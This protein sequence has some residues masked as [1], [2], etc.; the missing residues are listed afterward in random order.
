MRRLFLGVDGGG[1]STG[2]SL[3]DVKGRV[4]ATASKKTI[5][6]KQVTP[7][8]LKETLRDGIDEVLGASSAQV[9]EICYAFFGVPGY[10]EFREAM[11]TTDEVIRELLG[12]DRFQCGNDCVAGWAG[13][14]AAK[15]GV[16]MVLGTGV[17]AY[18]RDYEDNE[19]RSSGWGPFC[20]D[21]G[22]AY[23]LG[24]RAI[25][26]FAQQ[27]DGRLPKGRLYQIIKDNYQ[28][29]EDFDLISLVTQESWGRAEIAKIAQDLTKAAR[30]G[31]RDA[32]SAFDEAA[33]EV[34]KAIRAVIA[35]LNFKSDE[36]IYVTYSGGVFKVGDL[37]KTP[38]YH[39]LQEDPRIVVSASILEPGEGAALMAM[40][41]YGHQVT[42]EVIENLKG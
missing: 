13:S 30:E 26:L 38:I 9:S 14:Q 27:S 7:E 3:A 41:L 36:T 24:R 16:N 11:E 4:L 22:S 1:T 10:G 32:L 42:D 20:G 31:D 12:S 8:A 17:I 21:E 2:F 40:H 19:A 37:I 25:T 23:W 29:E 18:G 28:I 6:L 39:R 33:D 15:P 5:H 35:K 34:A